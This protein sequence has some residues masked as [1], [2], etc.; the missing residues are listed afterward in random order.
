[1]PPAT[2]PAAPSAAS[3][4]PVGNSSSASSS[5]KP[6]RAMTT[7]ASIARLSALERV[8]AH[9]GFQLGVLGVGTLLEVDELA[10]TVVEGGV[11][12]A[13]VAAER[14][15]DLFAGIAVAGVG[16]RL[17]F[18]ERLGGIGIVFGV[19]AEEGDPLAVAGGELLQHRELEAAGAAPGGP[20]VDDDRVAGERGDSLLVGVDPVREELVCLLVQGG[21][22]RWRAGQ[23]PLVVGRSG[24]V[25][26]ALGGAAAG[27]REGDRGQRQQHCEKRSS[28]GH[29][30]VITIRTFGS[31]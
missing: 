26:T 31:R 4:P 18:E 12:E 23:G 19:H 8:A 13:A 22:R 3:T 10:F 30:S 16:D 5:A 24:S 28:L 25:A 11:G 9:V 2:S 14:V 20:D 29:G 7:N 15:E 21:Q 17:L 27:R 1:M 6:A